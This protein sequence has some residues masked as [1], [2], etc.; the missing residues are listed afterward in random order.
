MLYEE[1]KALLDNLK[2]ECRHSSE[3]SFPKSDSTS[4]TPSPTNIISQ[5]MVENDPEQCF[6]PLKDSNDELRKKIVELFVQLSELKSF[7]ALNLTAFTK[8]LKKYDKIA[9]RNLK[10]KYIANRVGMSYPFKTENKDGVE[11]QHSKY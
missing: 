2:N 4:V 10:R 1:M 8:I 11:S 3:F 9:D 6:L 7:V 5:N